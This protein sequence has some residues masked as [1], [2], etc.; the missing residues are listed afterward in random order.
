MS[1]CLQYLY[2]VVSLQPEVVVSIP[3]FRHSIV[4]S[5][6]LNNNINLMQ[7]SSVRNFAIKLCD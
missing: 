4:L 5:P 1:Q 6:L 2:I 3:Q 7:I